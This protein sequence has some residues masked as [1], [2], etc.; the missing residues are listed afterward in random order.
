MGPTRLDVPIP[1]AVLTVCRELR[2]HR[3]AAFVVGGAVRDL[4]LGRTPHDFDV[5]TDARP[6]TVLAIFP[7]TV[8]TGL[9]HGTVTVVPQ[10]GDP[11][12]VTTFR[13]E[14][15][16]S[17]GRHPDI[18]T[19]VDHIEEDLARRDFTINAMA[20]EPLGR[21]IVDP[22]GGRRD[23]FDGVLR[24]VGKP[25]DR[26]AEDGLR[27]M[28]AVRFAA[29]LGFRLDAPMRAAITTAIPTFRKVA[30]ER[31][32]DELVKMLAAPKP[33]VGLRLMLHTGLLTE[34]LPE[35]LP[36]VGMPQNRHHRFDV[37]DHTLAVVDAAPSGLC[38][39]AAVLHDVGKPA[40][41]APHPSWPGEASFHGHD[42]AGAELAA[43]ILERLKF[44]NEERDAI[45]GL[46]RHHML[47]VR[48]RPWDGPGIRRFVRKVGRESLDDLFALRRADIAG[49][50]ADTSVDLADLEALEARVAAE[51][52][53]KPPLAV[54]DL[55][56]DGADVMRVLGCKPG[57]IVGA[58]LRGLM[59]RVLDDPSL[60]SH[61]TLAALIP[62]AAREATP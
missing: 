61:E 22:F 38:R 49:G 16:F 15:G 1:D 18:V 36:Q 30:V 50:K 37:W 62:T 44:S 47:F 21:E 9:K 17:D 12:E 34:V 6:E 51:L 39:L 3:H 55:A 26:F 5:A 19:F 52:E 8:A 43:G 56:V 32:R 25:E 58:V 42:A 10:V 23:L 4:L 53:R 31:I 20:L 2:R 11:V 14:R 54:T 40:T 33:S 7:H 57:K 48:S 41:R 59:Q 27:V 45:V 28:R 60:N 35:M 24:C 13:S 29:T 46:V